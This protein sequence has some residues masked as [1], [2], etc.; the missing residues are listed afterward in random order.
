MLPYFRITFQ[1]WVVY[2]VSIKIHTLP[3]VYKRWMQGNM[4]AADVFLWDIHHPCL[5]CWNQREPKRCSCM[6]YF[7]PAG[8]GSDKCVEGCWVSKSSHHQYPNT[9][10]NCD[11]S[12][13][14][15]TPSGAPENFLVQR[16]AHACLHETNRCLSCEGNR[17]LI[18][19]CHLKLM[20]KHVKR[21]Q[22]PAERKRRWIIIIGYNRKHFAHLSF[23]RS[24]NFLDGTL[25]ALCK[26]T[27]WWKDAVADLILPVKLTLTRRR[28][29]VIQQPFTAALVELTCTVWFPEHLPLKTQWCC[30]SYCHVEW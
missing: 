12:R 26:M 30:G 15:V 11:F 10:V 19:W 27:L 29:L 7:T 22:T 16:Q 13:I 6:T 20:C 4:P 24:S 21:H 18:S 23:K 8:S 14:S 28:L 9:A 1:W 17:L 3:A 2:V 5:L 25:E